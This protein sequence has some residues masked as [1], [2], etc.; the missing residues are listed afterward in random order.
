MRKKLRSFT[1]AFLLLA[2]TFASS[3]HSLAQEAARPDRG[4]MPN[5]SY[6]VSDIENINLL[7]GNVNIRIPLASLPPIAGGKLS[8]TI[9]AQ[10]NSKLWN[11][12]REQQN[13]DPMTWQPYLVDGPG[14]DGGWRI[15]STYQFIFR[16]IDDDVDRAWYP[17]NSGVPAWDLHLINDFQW[18]KVVLRMPDG[19]EH[20]FRPLDLI[21]YQ[22][23]AADFLKGF[24][25]EKP[26]GTAKRYYSVDGTFMFAR[27]SAANDWTVYLRD[28]TQ[29]IQTPAGVQWIQDTNGNKIKIFSDANGTHY[30]DE[31]TLREIRL[32]YNPSGAGQYQVWY[33]TVGGGLDQHIDIN[34][35]TTTVAGK[36]YAVNAPSC[37]SGPLTAE[38]SSQLEVVREIVL[39]PTEPGP[40]RRFTFSYNSDTSSQQTDPAGFSCPGGGPYTRAVSYG[41]GELS[42]IV[43]PLGAVVNY[44]YTHDGVST[45]EPFGIDD[46]F[47]KEKITEKEIEGTTDIWTYDINDNFGTMTA[48]DGSVSTESAYCSLPGSPTCP[49]DKA[50]LP[51]GSVQPFTKV[52]R[53]Y[54]N[55][56]FAGADTNSPNGPL[57]FNAVVDK[58]Y[59]SLT[60]AQGNAL[61][62]SARAF[63]FDYNGNVTQETHY[64][65]F[66]PGLV[67]RDAAGVPTGIPASATVL[68]VITHSHYNQAAGGSS[69]NVYA[70]RS[71]PSGTPLILNAPRETIVGPGKVRFSYDG[72][73]YDVAPTVGNLTTKQV[74][75]DLDAK[76]IT[77]SNTYDLSGNVTGSTD[78][79]GK[80]TQF[81]YDDTTH[82]LPTRVVVDPQNATGTQTTSTSYDF[83]TGLVVS[84]TDPNGQISEISYTNQ[85]L[86]TADPFGRPGVTTSPA[87][88]AGGTNQKRLVT[89]TYLDSARQVIVAAD[90]NAENDKLLKTK[91]TMDTL[92][93]PV[94]TESTEDGTNY[95]I[96][97]KYAYLNMG[98]VTLTSS[99]M[100]GSDAATDSWTR[101]TKDTA[102]RVIEV[103]T[104][105]GAAQP[106]WT[107]TAGSFTGAVTTAYTANFTTVTDQAGKVRR[108]MVDALGRLTRVDEPDAS[109]NLGSTA[110]PVQP[111]SYEYNINDNLTRVIQGSQ[112]R[113]FTYDSL[114]RL[115][116]AQNPESGTVN[117]QYDD[118]GNL[119]VK[120]DA[121]AD[122]NDSTKKVSTHFEY[123]A[124]NRITR[125]WYNGS[126]LVTAITHNNPT[127]PAFVG[128]TD[129]VKFYYDSQALS[130]A[131]PG[132]NRGSAIGRLVAQIYGTGSNGDYYQYDVLGR[133]TVKFQQMGS[134][135]YKLTA[136]YTLSGTV[137]SLTYPSNHTIT[138]AYDQA[139]RLTAFSGDLDGA[140]RMYSTGIVYSPLSSLL[141]EQF[142]TIS[143]VYHKFHYNSRAQICDV[144]ASAVNDEWGG[145]L[146]ALTFYYHTPVSHC[147]DGPNNNGNLVMSQTILNSVYFEDRYTYDSLNRLTSVSEYENETTLVGTQQY[148][149]DRW[150][151][152]TI[153][154]T[155]SAIFNKKQFTVN[156]ANNRLGV[157][158]GQAG[159]ME[160]DA[161]GNL[162]NDTYTGAGN[163]TYDAENK[164]TSA[165]GGNNQA[166]TYKYD[167][168]GQRIKRT[169]NGDETW[170]VYGFGGELLAE[171]AANG[172]PSSP[173]KEYGYRNGQLLVTAEPALSTNVALASNGAVATA[174]SSYSSSYPVTAVIDGDH[175]GLN[176]GNGGGWNCATAD[177]YPDW[178]EVDFG[179]NKTLVELDVFT[180]QDALATAEPTEAMSFTQYGIVNFKVEYWNNSAFVEVPGGNVTGNN[181]VWRKFTFAPITT[182]KVRVWV[183]NALFHNSRIVEIEAW[184]ATA[185]PARQN[186]A[187][188]SSG[189]SVAASSEYSA[190]Y[191]ASSVING[192]RRG[193]N[194]GNGGG[195][196]D[197]A[198][199]NTFPD[200][201]TITF[202]GSRTIDEIDVFTLQDNFSSPVEPTETM[203]F[204]QWGLTGYEV[205][206]WNNS[207]WTT[208]ATVTGENKVWR[209]F[210]FAPVITDKIR[211]STTGSIDGHSRI[212]EVEAWAPMPPTTVSSVH[213]LVSDH[214]GTPRMVIDQTGTLA[215]VKRHD[216]LP[217]GEELFAGIGGRSET[218]G[219]KSA[220][221]VRQQFTQK[222]RDIETGLDY[223]GARFYAS[224][225][226]RFTSADPLY[227]SSSRPVDPQQF[228]L[229]S[230]VRNN[231]LRMVDPDGRDG[232]VTGDTPEALEQ[233]KKKIKRIA[234]GTRID[235][236]GKIHKPGFFRRIWNRV[237]GHGAGTS[238]I[239][240]I[241]DSKN[242]TLIHATDK[243]TG[244]AGI[245]SSRM[246]PLFQ[247]ISGCAAVRCNYYI[248][249]SINYKG[250]SHDR[251]PDGSIGQGPFDLG[252][253]LGHELVHA[254]IF[255][256]FGHTFT[257]EGD[258]AVHS[259]T[260]GRGNTLTETSSAGEFLA[261]GLPFEYQGT[262]KNVPQKWDIT[263]NRLRRELLK[264]PRLRATYK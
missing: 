101:V 117:Y 80:L 239:S 34:M 218:L 237:T 50:G 196:N 132:Y 178:V 106:A 107:G 9:T 210:T 92:G 27:I 74:W 142:G 46:H 6:S 57:P 152:R 183:T 254:D 1:R 12:T 122:P 75:V 102:G 120:T 51:Y 135:N 40:Q 259:Y 226:G 8:W 261:T 7:N 149:Y 241:A 245:V 247:Q 148:D 138:N 69:A 204:T 215:N 94:L 59:T 243:E 128:A 189:A 205:Q 61:K 48:P 103:A 144:R 162:T 206:Y 165:W 15:G 89:T 99:P 150:G 49:S 251:M 45:F 64:D 127:L 23:Q 216:Y 108:S 260:D 147:G 112:Q 63:V 175:R 161:A 28:G 104:F 30:R 53:H 79:R 156:P 126:S 145:E 96:A 225:H 160:Y 17:G 199:V 97:V 54:I 214:L 35:G 263:E 58:E 190:S 224:I 90:L 18:W 16:N 235:A 186:V 36:L 134:K 121:R 95:T 125:R 3:F 93:R 56:V 220:D 114:S 139:G 230:Y 201:V 84:Q 42:R 115:R 197:A 198:P 87:V 19:A 39:P 234:P 181:K 209:K 85:L 248:E 2:S 37:S 194:W 131:P 222:E 33:K 233:A 202:N 136:N 250:T 231:P 187:L 163:R 182:S 140:A 176:W 191:P 171:Y 111:T 105:G 10:Y 180:L 52:E 262:R 203:T 62:M 217:F 47:A 66:D 177:Q 25:N 173:Q 113:T 249:L 174:S 232:Y 153:K 124:L 255:N 5:G 123:D 43:T 188:A 229:Y 246:T 81:F 227:Y 212:V 208:L 72:E 83:S 130:G 31:Q 77:T 164:M 253:A 257:E 211:V 256:H 242:V 129:E 71:I 137:S 4:I 73:A 213:W 169:V 154:D 82:A 141:K 221:G 219:Y 76:W 223:F 228:N 67:S 11:I 236:N 170:Q 185:P 195:W 32:T 143:P 158:G 55:L 192:E 88:N 38:L 68:K 116:S 70:K 29:V 26:T 98:Q 110:V 238:L 167:G 133:Q 119:L 157:P 86:G 155:S 21:S 24:F 179:S 168:A 146:G 184:T 193:V 100:R 172:D 109:G 252:V 78:G 91:T 207:S 151:N 65:W 258:T 14:V 118:T 13:D 60:D 264:L 200:T 159:I 41:L 20:E 166:Q 240:R 44:S 244:P 22:G